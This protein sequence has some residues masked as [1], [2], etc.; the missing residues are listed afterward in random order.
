GGAAGHNGL[1]SINDCIFSKNYKRMRFGVGRPDHKVDI[2][3]YVLSNFTKD[4][5]DM[6]NNISIEKIFT[7][8]IEYINK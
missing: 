7:D 3:N 4:E 5:I 1:R 8:I 6:I 2:A